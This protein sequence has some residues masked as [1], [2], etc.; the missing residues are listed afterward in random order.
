LTTWQYEQTIVWQNGGY[1]ISG[2]KGPLRE[3][4]SYTLTPDGQTVETIDLG[5]SLGG[6]RECTVDIVSGSLVSNCKD[7]STNQIDM[8]AT[9]TIAP[10]NP[11]VM[12]FKSKDVPYNYEM[13][14]T[15]RRRT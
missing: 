5:S 6:L 9:R 4:F 7:P 3:T 2:I 13:V 12:Y 14:A 10:D 15:M 1:H 8:I 11:N